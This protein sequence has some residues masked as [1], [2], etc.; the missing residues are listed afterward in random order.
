MPAALLDFGAGCVRPMW[1]NL[2]AIGWIVDYVDVDS[3][4]TLEAQ[5]DAGYLRTAGTTPYHW[6][7]DRWAVTDTGAGA[8]LRSLDYPDDRP[9]R[10]VSRTV[11]PLKGGA[12][13]V[14]FEAAMT[15]ILRDEQIVWIA[16]LD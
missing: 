2:D 10:E 4:R 8:E 16:R 3:D 14:M 11:T 12:V 5:M 9:M 6:R 15:A 13:I 7:P 1:T